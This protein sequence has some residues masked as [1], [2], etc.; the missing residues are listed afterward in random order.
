MS[1]IIVGNKDYKNLH[2][3]KLIDSFDDIKRCNMS[4]PIGINGNKYGS[5][6]FC[7]HLYQNLITN[8]LSKSEF[9]SQYTTH[10]LRYTNRN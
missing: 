9:Y 10:L 8:K 3:G 7:C 6:G 5:L 1:L 2:L 4:L